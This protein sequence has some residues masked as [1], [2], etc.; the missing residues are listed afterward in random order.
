MCSSKVEIKHMNETQ[1][2]PVIDLRSDTLTKP[3]DEMR[4]AMSRALVGD[5]VFEEDPTVKE[6]EKKSAAYT[7]KEAALFVCSGTMANVIAIMVHCD[8][9]GCEAYCGEEYHAFLH[10]QG[11]AAQIAGVNLCILPS[12]PDG[13]F[14][15]SKLKDKLRTDRLHEPISK[16]VFAENPVNGKVVPQA[17]IEELAELAKS[18]DLKLHLDGARIFNAS[19]MVNKPVSYLVSPFDSVMFCLSKSLG[20]PI[21]SVLCGTK[22][23]IDKARRIRKVLGGAWRQ[24][25]VM[26]AA[27][28]VA[29]EKIVP[30][31]ANDHRNA[32]LITREINSLNSSVFN[33]D[34]FSVQTNMI[35]LNVRS[36]SISPADFVRRL[37]EVHDDTP[38]DKVIIKCMALRSTSIRIVLYHQINPTMI[39]AAIRKIKHVIKQMEIQD[40]SM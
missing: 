8:V 33:V 39:D 15:L 11:A 7:G 6:L 3:T 31:L 14:D 1:K 2:F 20:A 26:A 23:F 28:L 4:E 18:N 5:D 12:N 10:E 32:M 38:D 29:L 40:K 21:G 16:L 24:A 30:L 9:R 34:E 27:G 35:F 22:S 37:Q 19:V 36:N 13:S 25:G 17:W